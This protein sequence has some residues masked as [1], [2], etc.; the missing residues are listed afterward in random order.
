[1]RRWSPP[2][3]L[4]SHTRKRNVPLACGKRVFGR[5][6]AG[7]RGQRL[8]AEAAHK[9]MLQDLVEGGAVRRVVAEELRYEVTCRR[10]HTRREAVLVGRDTRVRLL[11]RRRL[12]RGTSYQQRVPE[13]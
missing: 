11:E 3:P 13:T 10:R 1:M 4:K 2:L 9:L 8:G 12:E 7:L 6:F 5:G